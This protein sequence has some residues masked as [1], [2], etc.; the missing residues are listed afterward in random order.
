MSLRASFVGVVFAVAACGGSVSIFG[1]N[2]TTAGAGGQP[3]A[4]SAASGV[5][6]VTSG[7]ATTNVSIAVTTATGS[8]GTMTTTVTGAG[9]AMTGSVTAVTVSSTAVTATATASSSSGGG[10]CMHDPCATGAALN[11]NC[12]MCVTQLCAQDKYCCQTSWDFICVGKVWSVCKQDCS[13]NGPSCEKQ[14]STAPGYQLCWQGADCA[15]AFNS[16]QKTCAAICSDGGGECTA[17]Y[18]D[19]NNQKCQ[20]GQKLACTTNQLSSGVCVCSRGCGGGAP[21]MQ[22]QKCTAGKCA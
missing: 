18:N 14:Y 11:A 7:P 21:C 13:P 5:T 16:T 2:E 17:V 12:D 1:G 15:L 22:G 20:V 10:M 19:V 6:G 8:G 4:T 3:A 9:G